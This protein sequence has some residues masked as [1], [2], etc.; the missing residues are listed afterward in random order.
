ML[1]SLS[2]LTALPFDRL[3]PRTSVTELQRVESE[4]VKTFTMLCGLP[5]SLRMLWVGVTRRQLPRGSGSIVT[6]EIESLRERL[7]GN[8]SIVIEIES[9]L[10]LL[11][12]DV[13]VNDADRIREYLLRF[14]GMIDVVLQAVDAARRHFPEAQLVMEVYQDPEIDDRYLVLYVRLKQYNDSIVERLQRAEAEF[15][16]HLADTEG[17]LQLTTDFREPEAEDV[18]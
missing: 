11:A 14:P 18:L 5:Q 3:G 10:N 4:E 2:R 16:D 8:V 13:R 6:E 7:P 17:W 15:L 12:E 9:L 1:T